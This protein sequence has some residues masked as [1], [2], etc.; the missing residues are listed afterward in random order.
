MSI[1]VSACFVC[2]VKLSLKH[3]KTFSPALNW[4]EILG[5]LALL[6]AL[7]SHFSFEG[8]TK[9]TLICWTYIRRMSQERLRSK[10]LES[11]RG[12]S[13]IGWESVATGFQEC[14]LDSALVSPRVKTDGEV[15]SLT[16]WVSLRGRCC[17]RGLNRDFCA[18]RY[19]QRHRKVD[20]FP[21]WKLTLWCQLEFSPQLVWLYQSLPWNADES[22]VPTWQCQASLIVKTCLW[23]RQRHEWV[24]TGQKEQH[25]PRSV[26]GELRWP[27]EE[28]LMS[29]QDW[30]AAGVLPRDNFMALVPACPPFVLNLSHSCV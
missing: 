19:A 20:F 8:R 11:E 17:S 1:V 6:L 5:K 2:I 23:D 30:S 9:Q 3:V 27:R 29:T 13:R 25:R 18:L 12:G 14:L 7:T 4:S 10:E 16:A 26:P 24:P 15:K 21:C 22:Q 28:M